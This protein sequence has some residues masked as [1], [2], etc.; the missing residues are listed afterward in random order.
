MINFDPIASTYDKL[1]HLMSWNLDNRWRRKAAETV[2]NHAEPLHYLDIAAG[3][4]D[5]TLAIARRAAIGSTYTNIDLS[6]KMLD[7]ARKKYE[8]AHLKVDILQAS[9]AEMPFNDSSFQ[10][11][12]VAFGVRNFTELDKSLAEMHRVLSNGG[13]LAILELST[14]DNPLIFACYK[15]YACHLLPWLGKKM[16]GNKQAYTYLPQSILRFPKGKDFM[17]RLQTAGFEEI[18]QKKLFMGVCRLYT[19]TK[20]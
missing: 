4:G 17:Q 20:R 12:S 6:E 8:A 7:E 15:L 1:N 18:R 14:P 3:T 5:M 10:A 11:C 9:A 16:A 2:A 13:R 19:C